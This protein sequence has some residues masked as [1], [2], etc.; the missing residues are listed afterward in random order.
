MGLVIQ[1]YRAFV[2][3]HKEF[4]LALSYQC[5]ETIEIAIALLRSS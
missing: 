1:F 3:H 2:L 4:K 5:W